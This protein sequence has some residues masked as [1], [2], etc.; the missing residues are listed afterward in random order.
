MGDPHRRNHCSRRPELTR[1]AIGQYV[2]NYCWHHLKQIERT[3]YQSEC[4]AFA[5]TTDSTLPSV[6]PTPQPIPVGDPT[7]DC[8]L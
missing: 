2:L 1:P 8:S 5:Y 3:W 6:L 4:E 7:A